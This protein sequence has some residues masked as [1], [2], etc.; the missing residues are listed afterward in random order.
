MMDRRAGFTLIELLL[1]T[2]LTAMV[3]TGALFSLSVILNAYKAYG[4]KTNDAEIANMIFTRMRLDLTAAFLSPHEDRTRFVCN[5]TQSGDLDADTLTFIGMV[6]EP[7]EIGQ[8]TSDLAEVQYYIDDD[9]STP[10]R[11]LVRRFD[12]TPD[13]DPFTGGEIALLGPGVQTIDFQFFDG[14]EWWPLWDSSS[15][16]P[17]AVNV[18]IGFFH[19]EREG[20]PPVAERMQTFSTT[21][22]I[23][24]SRGGD[25]LDDQALG[26]TGD[27]EGQGQGQGQQ[28]GG[29]Q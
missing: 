13:D 16:L 22:W 17:I 19:P 24:L 11:W 20:E 9:D 21:F 7:V 6:N 8:G 1:A 25:A 26:L 4:G 23:A 12:N 27:E 28:Q 14:T 3:V 15:S 2:A 5:D 10:E 18:R 29:G